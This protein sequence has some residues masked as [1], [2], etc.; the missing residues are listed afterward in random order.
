MATLVVDL[1]DAARGT[2]DL[3]FYS[4]GLY[5]ESLPPLL[6]LTMVSTPHG[7]LLWSW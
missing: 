1:H 2:N 4:I 5:M 6:N 7:P 3:N